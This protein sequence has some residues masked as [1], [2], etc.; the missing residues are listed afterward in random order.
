VVTDTY[1]WSRIGGHLALDLCNT[2]S[3]RLDPARTAE[4]LVDAA[5]LG[6]WFR[7]VTDHSG[8]VRPG[9][10]SLRTVHELRAATTRL[11][12]AHLDGHVGTPADVTTVR[13]AW[14]AA[15]AIADIPPLL[16]LTATIEP[17]TGPRL[18]A[19]LALAVA[20][21]LH[22]SDLSKLRRCDGDG[23]GWFFLDTTRN[24]SRRWCDSLDC[25][26]R[27]RVRAYSRRRRAGST[28]LRAS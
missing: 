14:R 13:D 8:P 10:L 23:C 5:E 22:R 15:L 7:A 12:D 17:S 21:L 4:R 6:A 20:D 11:L 24:R 1:A 18:A 16:P 2:I 26:N 28:P 25:G 9:R 27:A 19:N 3:W